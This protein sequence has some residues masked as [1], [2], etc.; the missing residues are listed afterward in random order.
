M[1]AHAFAI[2][3]I[4]IASMA[5][6]QPPDPPETPR[7]I[8]SGSVGF[9]VATNVFGTTVKGKSRSLTG[10]TRLRESRDGRLRLD[11][12]EAL[13]PVSTLRTGIALR[14]VHMRQ[15][16]FE[17]DDHQTPDVRFTAAD[18]QCH[19]TAKKAYAC[20]ASGTLSIR[21]TARPFSIALA[22][23]RDADAFRVKG[24]GKVALS[25]YGIERPSQFGVRT[26]D[27]V[28][29][30]LDFSARHATPAAHVR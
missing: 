29:I 15:Y 28:A 7:M 12:I 26:G 24:N 2:G 9:E 10:N 30:D 14:D 4:L 23:T 1:R 16:I 21:G 18:A 22:V 19:R 13:V 20:T 27:D 3:G 8:V 17:T 11:A 6:A 5:A 25:A